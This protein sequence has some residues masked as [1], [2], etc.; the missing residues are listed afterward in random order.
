ML[1]GYDHDAQH[2]QNAGPLL[3]QSVDD[4]GEL[5]KLADPA[6]RSVAGMQT[7]QR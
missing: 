2:L 4:F 5:V 6:Y 7:S 3:A 1:F